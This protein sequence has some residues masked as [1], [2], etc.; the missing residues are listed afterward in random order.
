MTKNKKMILLI[1]TIVTVFIQMSINGLSQGKIFEE[2]IYKDFK[3]IEYFNYITVFVKSEHAEEIGLKS[4]ELTKYAK[5]RF[6]N[7]FS[8]I[9]YKDKSIPFYA[10]E[11]EK[12]R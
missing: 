12:K 3:Y 1:I 5:L 9:E 6:K 8:S 4:E 11:I 2:I 7:N 10:T